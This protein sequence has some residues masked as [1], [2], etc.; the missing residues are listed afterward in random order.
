[1]LRSPGALRENGNR[2]PSLYYLLVNGINIKAWAIVLSLREV[3]SFCKFW[4]ECHKYTVS[5]IRILD[6]KRSR[7]L[8]RYCC[9]K[10]CWLSGRGPVS[11]LRSD[12]PPPGLGWASWE[13]TAH[14]PSSP[15]RCQ[16]GAGGRTRDLRRDTVIEQFVASG[17][18]THGLVCMC[19]FACLPYFIKVSATE[20]MSFWKSGEGTVFV[21]Q[22]SISKY[23]KVGGLKQPKLAVWQF[24]ARSPKS[25]FQ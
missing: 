22:A 13:C 21:S 3:T 10:V 14:N 20:A 9:W 19:M 16:G 7:K 5:R 6:G 24:E 23:H 8:D 18:F 1:M 11:H 17:Y 4:I 12:P 25:R 15:G 2:A